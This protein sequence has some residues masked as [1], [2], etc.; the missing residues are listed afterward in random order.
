MKKTLFIFLLSIFG[1]NICKSYYVGIYSLDFLPSAHVTVNDDIRLVLVSIFP[2]GSSSYAPPLIGYYYTRTSNTVD[3]FVYYDE[4]GPWPQQGS[5][6]VDTFNLDKFPKGVYNVRLHDNVTR[7]G[8]D[9]N[10]GNP[11]DLDSLV[12]TVDF[13]LSVPQTPALTASVYPNPV[14]SDLQVRIDDLTSGTS[15]PVEIE[16]TDV[17]GKLILRQKCTSSITFINMRDCAPGLYLYRI[18]SN[19]IVQTKGEL[20]KE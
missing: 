15:V 16:L 9:T 10:R 8:I 4:S 13:P 6:A 3:V 20:K 5:A 11:G 7:P 12:L 18:M 17:T 1:S 19:G 14:T 2:M